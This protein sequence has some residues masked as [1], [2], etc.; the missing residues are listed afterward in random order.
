MT[1]P[2]DAEA[3]KA[4]SYRDVIWQCE[5]NYKAAKEALHSTAEKTRELQGNAPVCVIE[6]VA[7]SSRE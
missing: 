3:L 7:M 1:H 5:Y 6:G 4:P 2:F